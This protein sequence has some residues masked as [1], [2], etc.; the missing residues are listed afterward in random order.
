M[1]LNFSFDQLR[2]IFTLPLSVVL[3]SYVKGF[4][5]KVIN[6]I[7]YTNSKLYEIGFKT[8]DLCSFCKAE[9]ETRYHLLYQC[10]FVRQSWNEF[11]DYWHQLSNQHIRLTL[12]DVLFGIIT[13]P[14]PLLDLLNY[15]IMIR[16]LFLWDCRRTLIRPRIQGFQSK[17]TIKYETERKINKTNFFKKNWVLSPV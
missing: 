14:C 6:S 9:S 4:R 2:E 11:Q 10:S 12:Q 7:L 15:F 5:F 1:T 8:D 16:K 13:K 17:I 3:E